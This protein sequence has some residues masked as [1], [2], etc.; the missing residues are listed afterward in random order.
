MDQGNGNNETN[1]KVSAPIEL[2]LALWDDM[3]EEQQEDEEQLQEEETMDE[4]QD[5]CDLPLS[6]R[7]QRSTTR[8]TRKTQ[9]PDDADDKEKGTTTAES[10]PT[11]RRT[12]TTKRRRT[13]ERSS[14]W[15]NLSTL[16]GIGQHVTLTPAF[17]SSHDSV[18]FSET[19]VQQFVH[20]YVIPSVWQRHNPNHVAASAMVASI[21]SQW[22]QTALNLAAVQTNC[23]VPVFGWWGR[24]DHRHSVPQSLSTHEPEQQKLIANLPSSLFQQQPQAVLTAQSSLC[25]LQPSLPPSIRRTASTDPPLSSSSDPQSDTESVHGHQSTMSWDDDS[26]SQAT[27]WT[28]TT[29]HTSATSPLLLKQQQGQMT[30]RTMATTLRKD[31]LDKPGDLQLGFPTWL[32]ETWARHAALPPE[33]ASSLAPSSPTGRGRRN[34]SVTSARL[35]RLTRQRRR[36]SS[37]HEND[38]DGEYWND[39]QL[40]PL[41][42]GMCYCGE[43]DNDYD[44]YN[45]GSGKR[46]SFWLGT[47]PVAPYGVSLA[48]W[49]D[50]LLRYCPPTMNTMQDDHMLLDSLSESSPQEVVHLWQ[51]RH[52]Y[53][54]DKRCPP[55]E[56]PT[57]TPP[58]SPPHHH[59][60]GPSVR[61]SFSSCSDDPQANWRTPRAALLWVDDCK[62]NGSSTLDH[63]LTHA[64]LRQELQRRQLHCHL[65]DLMSNAA[66]A[67][68][69]DPLWGPVDDP[70]D[71]LWAS[72]KWKQ[73]TQP[74]MQ[75]P[76]KIRS[77]QALS[78][79]DH[80]EAQQA[81]ELNVMNP[82]RAVDFTLQV[83]H[84][85]GAMKTPLA[86]I[87]HCLLAALIRTSTLP[88]ET[89]LTHL[90]DTLVLERWDADAGNVIARNLAQQAPNVGSTTLNL[91]EAMDW[92]YAAED[93]IEPWQALEI[94]R[95]VFAANAAASNGSSSSSSS[96]ALSLLSPPSDNDN[97]AESPS[98]SS[99]LF[100]PLPKSAPYCRLF[101]ILCAYI[102]RVRSPSSMIQV[103]CTFVQELRRKWDFRESLPN[104][105]NHLPGYDGIP[106]TTDKTPLSNGDFLET[107]FSAPPPPPFAAYL[108]SAGTGN[109]GRNSSLALS[110]SDSLSTEFHCLIGQKLQVIHLCFETVIAEEESSQQQQHPNHLNLNGSRQGGS[111]A[112]MMSNNGVQGQ[113]RRRMDY[114]SLPPVMDA[115]RPPPSNS[116]TQSLGRDEEEKEGD[117]QSA[118]NNNVSLLTLE[119]AKLNG[120]TAGVS[121]GDTMG[122]K[123]KMASSVNNMNGAASVSSLSSHRDETDALSVATHYT[124]TRSMAT[125]STAT[126]AMAGRTQTMAPT[127]GTA[128]DASQSTLEQYY[129]SN[130][131]GDVPPE[132]MMSFLRR[133][134]RC[135]VEGQFMAGNHSDSHPQVYA[136]YLQRPPPL[137]DDMLAQR[138]EWLEKR[139]G[140]VTAEGYGEENCGSSNESPGGQ[141]PSSQACLEKDVMERL[142][143]AQA[144]QRPKLVSD[145]SAFK[146]ANPGCQFEDFVRW[147]GEPKLPLVDMD[148][149]VESLSLGL[150]EPDQISERLMALTW[151][152]WIKT[153]DDAS[154]TPAAEQEPLFCAS[155][156]VEIALDYL[157]TLHP[158]N[159]ISS[160]MAT[161]LSN[162]YHSLVLS[163]TVGTD[164]GEDATQ[165]PMVEAS[166]IRLRRKLEAALHLLSADSVSPNNTVG[167]PQSS[168]ETNGFCGHVSGSSLSVSPPVFS[169]ASLETLAPCETACRI[170]GENEM[171]LS[172]ALSLLHKLPHQYELVEQL[173]QQHQQQRRLQ[174]RVRLQ[175]RLQ[176]QQQ[177]RRRSS[178]RGAGDATAKKKQTIFVTTTDIDEQHLRQSVLHALAGTPNYYGSRHSTLAQQPLGSLIGGP[179]PSLTPILRE[180]LFRNTNPSYPCQLCVRWGDGGRNNNKR[181]SESSYNKS[182]SLLSSSSSS[183]SSPGEDDAF[184]GL[185]IAIAHT[186]PIW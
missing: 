111:L 93:L 47:L 125:H 109:E 100:Q 87:Q 65:L 43:V 152:F 110:T 117:D 1:T 45:D 91:V 12:T 186:K 112:M 4:E 147:Y 56:S 123:R 35:R 50:L 18:L 3:E 14:L 148:Y 165:I 21:L 158:A 24:Y 25:Q 11:R 61:R 76:L 166:L 15:S 139:S 75:L 2:Q 115:P 49:G 42:T 163:A 94:V 55:P 44:L 54:W 141:C 104:M 113:G 77:H 122:R 98:S 32:H 176:Q 71:S 157:E 114:E 30:S 140:F 149:S 9:K 153:W 41:L 130:N 142:N 69:D 150:L 102:S 62:T 171:L 107:A 108:G 161:N 180:Y 58:G 92:E 48:T 101:S 73:M 160:V 86:A 128:D 174:R 124:D 154:A 185:M 22:L 34:S 184:D 127:K 162:A 16:F 82:L 78:D 90:T 169:F 172:N 68:D 37:L 66:G 155:D 118:R 129:D 138:R 70:I 67:S 179:I 72:V 119:D 19:F 146:A 38:D 85:A 83:R 64:Q 13:K 181:K 97:A 31:N 5:L 159:L 23:Q 156:T 145:M 168:P 106:T 59:T 120:V 116:I 135:P 88:M 151:A 164:L 53:C 170:I 96:D 17:A 177:R 132:W 84:D 167:G 137:T 133:G 144:M 95:D 28:T 143:V 175:E 131:G 126:T 7:R 103:F 89:L 36:S 105:V 6:L 173:L 74:L 79:E 27:F 40:P 81:M 26:T 39:K 136:P 63:K 57:A 182:V 99:V 60:H 51:A 178:S 10:T 29:V 134:A 183:S 33:P 20:T 52:V 46:A 80:R 8:Q 121:Q